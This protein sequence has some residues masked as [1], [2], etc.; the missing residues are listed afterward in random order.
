MT[1][2]G[3]AKRPRAALVDRLAQR[4]FAAAPHATDTIVV[5]IPFTGEPLGEV[6]RGQPEDVAEAVERSREVQRDWRTVSV[7]ER[8]HVLMRFH[9][10]VFKQRRHVLDLLQLEGG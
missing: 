2:E 6:P 7:D 8:C 9:D 3:A 5:D 4:A 1:V 10:L